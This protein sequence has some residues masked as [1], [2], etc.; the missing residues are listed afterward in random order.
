MIILT[1]LKTS[2]V[3]ANKF[4]D[5]YFP[6][7]V[8]RQDNCPEKFVLFAMLESLNVNWPLSR[9]RGTEFVRIYAYFTDKADTNTHRMILKKNLHLLKIFNVFVTR[10]K[11]F[12]KKTTWMF[13]KI[14]N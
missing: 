1:L 4:S 13:I 8:N 14:Q 11:N 5:E 2:E 6:M 10:M 7:Q 3:I 9:L 12:R